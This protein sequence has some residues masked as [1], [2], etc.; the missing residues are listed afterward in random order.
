MCGYLKQKIINATINK[1]MV[2]L[3]LKGNVVTVTLYSFI[4]CTYVHV[5]I[6]AC[7]NIYYVAVRGQLVFYKKIE[8]PGI[9]LVDI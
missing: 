9:C 6:R 1:C 7:R 2:F 4:L 3:L 8:K 5:W